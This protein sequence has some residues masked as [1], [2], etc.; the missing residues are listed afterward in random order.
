MRAFVRVVACAM[1]AVFS[2]EASSTALEQGRLESNVGLRKSWAGHNRTRTAHAWA[3]KGTQQCASSLRIFDTFVR[4]T[5]KVVYGWTIAAAN[6]DKAAFAAVIVEMRPHRHLQWVV[7]NVMHYLGSSWALFVVH[8]TQ[9]EAYVKE[10][11]KGSSNVQYVQATLGGAPIQALNQHSYG[12]Y[13]MTSDFWNIFPSNVKKVLVFQTD[14]AALRP[15]T[16]EEAVTWSSFDFVGAPWDF[17]VPNFERAESPLA[18]VSLVQ[19]PPPPPELPPSA[20]AATAPSA[21]VLPSIGAVLP[22]GDAKTLEAITGANK[23]TMRKLDAIIK[24]DAGSP[25]QSIAAGEHA[26]EAD[27]H[28]APGPTLATI[29]ATDVGRSSTALRFARS[30]L[31]REPMYYSG[32]GGFSLRSVQASKAVLSCCTELDRGNNRLPLHMEDQVFITCLVRNKF[33]VANH[34]QATNFA[35]ESLAMAPD[36]HPFGMHQAYCFQPDRDFALLMASSQLAAD[37]G[38]SE[39]A[40]AAGESNAREFL[41]QQAGTAPIPNILE[42]IALV[43]SDTSSASSTVSTKPIAMASNAKQILVKPSKSDA[44]SDMPDWVRQTLAEVAPT[45]VAAG[46]VAKAT[47]GST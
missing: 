37:T 6:P 3:H 4:A 32:N 23:D 45:G 35:V 31:K 47:V 7:K 26:L 14:T 24:D 16:A 44:K 30:H 34:A 36:Y 15:Y 21:P 18:P 27:S 25:E 46:A 9:N 33:K 40:R 10:A 28:T 20:T 19:G 1:M 42:P 43:Q 41:L 13:L 2:V 8:G 22:Q 5:S 39:A 38:F 11:L 29:T 17:P 12:F